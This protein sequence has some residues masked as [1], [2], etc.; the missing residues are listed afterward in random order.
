MSPMSAERIVGDAHR[1]G[2][3]AGLVAYL[4]N[5]LSV[6]ELAAGGGSRQ[7]VVAAHQSAD[8]PGLGN[9]P[10]SGEAVGRFAPPRVGD[11]LCTPARAPDAGLCVLACVLE[12]GGWRRCADR[13][14]VRT[15]RCLPR[16]RR[17]MI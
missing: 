4:M 5:A 7:P 2:S 13:V 17:V 11:T 9:H 16:I 14:L 8:A 12:T 3:G 10:L 1:A 15:T 6:L